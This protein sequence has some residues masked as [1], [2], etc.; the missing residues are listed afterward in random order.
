MT[1]GGTSTCHL[2]PLFRLFKGIEI[3]ETYAG[4]TCIDYFHQAGPLI[5]IIVSREITILPCLIVKIN[6]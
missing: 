4:K 3:I 1:I 6:L 2:P 5:A